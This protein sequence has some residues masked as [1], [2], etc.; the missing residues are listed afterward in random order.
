MTMIGDRV[1]VR[2]EEY[3]VTAATPASTDP[4][5]F[6]KKI[7]TLIELSTGK[8]FIGAGK[9]ITANS[10]LTEKVCVEEYSSVGED[11]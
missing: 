11:E 4:T 3:R 10:K 7:F 2:G 8:T 9:S 6:G 5:F 1:M